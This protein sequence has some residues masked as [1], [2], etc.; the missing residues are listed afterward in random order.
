MEVYLYTADGFELK[1]TSDTSDL[2]QSGTYVKAD[3]RKGQVIFY[4]GINYNPVYLPSN[5]SQILEQGSGLVNLNFTAASVRNVPTFTNAGVTLYQHN[6]YAGT[7]NAVYEDQRDITFGVSSMI[8]SGGRWQVFIHPDFQ[9]PHKTK[10]EG[11][12]ADPNSMGIATD[13]LRSIKKEDN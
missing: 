7:A 4:D 9:E 8:I 1:V 2:L 11:L 5:Q 3:C 6:L 13:T 10:G 12:Y